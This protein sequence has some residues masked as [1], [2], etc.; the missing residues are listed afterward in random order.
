MDQRYELTLRR[1]LQRADGQPIRAALHRTLAMPAF[2]LT[3]T[4]PRHADT[5]ATSE[6]EIKL[7]VQRRR[8]RRRGAA[9]PAFPRRGGRRI[10]ADV[11]QG[12]PEEVGYELGGT[13][14]LRTWAQEFDLA[15]NA[16]S[17]ASESAADENPTNPIAN[18]LIATPRT[19][20]PLGKG[21]KL[22][23]GAG[24]PTPGRAL[25][26]REAA[27]VPVGDVTPFVVTEVVA[28]H[29]INSGPLI[30]LSFSKPVPESLTNRIADWLEI[31]PSPTNL[32]VQAGW[33][34]LV[35]RGAFQ[36]GD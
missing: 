27:E 34:S 29:Y 9:V 22:V 24:L 33:R 6:P 18:L 28:S 36:G 10:A 4:W 15:R 5:N 21:W 12:T 2:G 17:S 23:V 3:S 14:S 20:L 25:R 7:A 11:R 31:S 30:R 16:G 1:G 26:L 35:L 13:S 8:P 32:T 19:P